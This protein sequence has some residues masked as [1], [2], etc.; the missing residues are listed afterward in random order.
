MSSSR[1]P[2][3]SCRTR[4]DTRA[5]LHTRTQIPFYQFDST[6]RRVF[7]GRE[8]TTGTTGNCPVARAYALYIRCARLTFHRRSLAGAPTKQRKQL[9][10]GLRRGH[11]CSAMKYW[12][13]GKKT[14]RVENCRKIFAAM[15]PWAGEKNSKFG[16]LLRELG[17]NN[18]N[19][20]VSR[21]TTVKKCRTTRK[22][23][24]LL[25][26]RAHSNLGPEKS[27]FQYIPCCSKAHNIANGST[28]QRFV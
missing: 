1:L 12:A 28:I 22:H 23:R 2:R 18:D 27:P 16:S 10:V 14:K 11:F 8:G 19:R 26:G 20:R 5:L 9:R 3:V 15:H 7:C 21:R 24:W 17:A 4:I 6:V 25:Q 13:Y